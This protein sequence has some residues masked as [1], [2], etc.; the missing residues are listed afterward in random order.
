MTTY[1][2]TTLV[3]ALPTSI[4]SIEPSLP[5]KSI[6]IH[7]IARWSSIFGVSEV[8]FYKEPLTDL[9][10]FR[11]H[12]TL[13][14]DHWRYFFTPPYLRK[15]LVP[16]TS[17]LKFVGM[18]PPI[19]LEVFNVKKKPKNGEIRLGYVFRN[20]EGGLKATVGDEVDY[21][22]IGEC[23]EEGLTTLLVIDEKEH[24]VKCIDKR[25]YTGPSVSFTTSLKGLLSKYR[26]LVNWIIA[27]DRK[28]TYPEKNTVEKLRGTTTLVLFGSPKYD[29][30]EIA[31]QE[32]F[33]LEDYVNYVWNTIPRQK[34][35]TVRTEEALVI[36]LGVINAFLR[37]I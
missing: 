30:F 23:G 14:E 15:K 16:L 11:E 21:S 28:G 9:I 31:N 33:Q 4:L 3:I 34:V 8:V 32:G 18:L 10:E 35:V 6:R 20:H 26:G 24:L 37:G 17:T 5:L 22:V 13:I 36:T 7:Q 12:K 2:K 27:T 19:R 25:V 29:L 1:L